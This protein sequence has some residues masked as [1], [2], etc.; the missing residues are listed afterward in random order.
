M[1]PQLFINYRLKSVEAMPLAA[2]LYRT[3][4]TFVDDLFAFVYVCL[5]FFAFVARLVLTANI[6]MSCAQKVF[7]CQTSHALA[8]SETISYLYS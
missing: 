3:I 4:N 2:F 7:Q 6:L 1:L 8:R 5:A